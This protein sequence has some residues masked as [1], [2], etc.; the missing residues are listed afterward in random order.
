MLTCY[1]VYDDIGM[2]GAV[3]LFILFVVGIIVAMLL[4]NH[5]VRLLASVCAVS[6]LV[7][8]EIGIIVPTPK[9]LSGDGYAITQEISLILATYLAPVVIGIVLG[10]VTKSLYAFI[11]AKGGK[12][13]ICNLFNVQ[14]PYDRASPL[15]QKQGISALHLCPANQYCKTC[16]IKRM[17]K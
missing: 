13:E 7:L 14:Y 5:R 11:K 3:F 2:Q 8:L 16:E 9:A 15:E 17:E 1:G 4:K 10:C 6:L 12:H